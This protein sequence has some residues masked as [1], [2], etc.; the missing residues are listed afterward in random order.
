MKVRGFSLLEVLISTV[1]LAVGLLGVAAMQLKSLQTSNSAYQR[2]MATI[3]AADCVERLWLNQ[4]AAAP[5]TAAQIQTEWLTHWR[6][7]TDHRV[8]LPDIAGVITAPAAGGVDYRVVVSWSE[9]RF[10]GNGTSSFTFD[11]KMYP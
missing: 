9:N 8:T 7:T 6:L 2:T 5:K 10:G 11:F 4:A 1:I 3:I